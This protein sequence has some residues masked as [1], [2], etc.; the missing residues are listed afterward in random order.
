MLTHMTPAAK[1]TPED[2]RHGDAVASSTVFSLAEHY[3]SLSTLHAKEALRKRVIQVRKVWRTLVF[4]LA[5]VLLYAVWC[6]AVLPAYRFAAWARLPR[7][8]ELF[9]VHFYP[10]FH[11]PLKIP[12]QV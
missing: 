4:L 3:S 1:V 10:C 5:L 2:S 11:R 6:V 8:P 7:L 12:S 9:I